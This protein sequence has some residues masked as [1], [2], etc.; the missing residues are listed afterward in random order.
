[1]AEQVLRI[2]EADGTPTGSVAVRPWGAVRAK[3]TVLVEPFDTAP[4]EVE[5]VEDANE[6]HQV[7][8]TFKGGG[9]HSYNVREKV[10]VLAYGKA[11]RDVAGPPTTETFR[12]SYFFPAGDTL[13]NLLALHRVLDRRV[14]RAEGHAYDELILAIESQWEHLKT[15]MEGAG[16]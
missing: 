2:T 5:S 15:L 8:V 12:E 7:Y 16:F 9:G 1:M 4:R 6:D 3:D 11:L 14:M 10:V 13:E